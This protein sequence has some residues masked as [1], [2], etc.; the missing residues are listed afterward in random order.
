VKRAFD[1]S[2]AVDS[3]S[4]YAAIEEAYADVLPQLD[5]AYELEL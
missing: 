3:A 1:Q 2:N 4:V 5:I